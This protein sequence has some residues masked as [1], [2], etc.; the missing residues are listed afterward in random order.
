MNLCF[1]VNL[2]VLFITYKTVSIIYEIKGCRYVIVYF[3]SKFEL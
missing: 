1:S 2:L 3:L